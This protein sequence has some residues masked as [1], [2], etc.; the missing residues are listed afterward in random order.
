ML[1]ASLRALRRLLPALRH[2]ATLSAHP[3]FRGPPLPLPA[4]AASA[5]ALPLLPPLFA[6]FL[7]LST[8]HAHADSPAPPPPDRTWPSLLRQLRSVQARSPLPPFTA[9]RRPLHPSDPRWAFQ[10]E[11]HPA[12][13]ADLYALLLHLAASLQRTSD[14]ARPVLS[15]HDSPTCTVLTV[16]QADTFEIA[17]SVPRLQ[18]CPSFRTRLVVELTKA[19]GPD[20]TFSA[21]EVD[22]LVRALYLTGPDPANH[23]AQVPV[24]RG[25]LLDGKDSVDIGPPTTLDR[26]RSPRSVRPHHHHPEYEYGVEALPHGDSG[27]AL[28]A[29]R[30]RAKLEEMGV[31]VFDGKDSA[32]TWDALAGYDDVKKSIEN[33]LTLPLKHPDVY[34]SIVRGTRKR[35]ESNLPKA[36]LYEGPPGCGK[37]LSA[38]ILSASIGIPFVHVPLETILSKFY[39][40]TTRKLADIL[41]TAN[42][43]GPCLVFIDECDSIGLSR[44]SSTE[45]HEVTR[46]TLSVLL[47]HID[48]LDGPQN[49][50]LLA[51]TNHKED[52]DSALMSRFDVVV[53]F[54]LPDVDTRAAVLAL[55]AKHLAPEELRTM[56]E[57]S[58]GFSGRELLDVCEEAERT[59][60]GNLVR[61]EVHREVAGQLPTLAEYVDAIQR[62]SPHIVARMQHPRQK[63]RATS[64]ETLQSMTLGPRP[65]LAM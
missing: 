18:A 39:G 25:S 58:A 41:Q 55:Y 65:A 3:S 57:L 6:A 10:L 34:E 45:V 5:A 40:E 8:S 2:H 15:V 44:S 61:E 36:V 21:E 37:T 24:A 63:G 53:S 54:P 13:S 33:T 59:Y 1:P 23:S 50:I 11:L 52:I 32:L 7:A 60:A 4:A 17:I 20:A 47:R 64:E 14:D 46:R 38:K 28:V 29:K 30:A 42:D 62:K 26:S 51:A 27:Q 22:A 56:A 16:A 48:G 9:S 35:F 12:P 49:T 19:A 31:D 43:L